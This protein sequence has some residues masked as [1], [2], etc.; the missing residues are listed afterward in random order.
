MRK[1]NI[2]LFVVLMVLA[3]LWGGCYYW[4][5]IVLSR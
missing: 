4:F 5:E 1:K 3:I 2:L